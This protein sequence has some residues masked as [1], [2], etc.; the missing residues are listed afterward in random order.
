MLLETDFAVGQ[1]NFTDLIINP[2]S[3]DSF[4]FFF[5][6]RTNRLVKRFILDNT[7][8]NVTY[9]CEVTLIRKGEK[10]APRLHFTIKDESGRLKRVRA[11]NSEDTIHLKASVSLKECYAQF[12]DLISYLKGLADIEG[13]PS[14]SFSLVSRADAEIVAALRQRDAGSIRSII[15]QLSEGVALSHDE[16]VELLQRKKRLK[17]FQHCLEQSA[18]ESHWQEFFEQN[19][20]IFGYGL[21]YVI[22]KVEGQQYVGGQ[23]IDHKG[24]QYPDYL[25]ITTGDVRF[26]VLVE[27]KGPATPLVQGRNE[28]RSGAWSLSKELTD[29]LAQVQ[30]NADRWNREGAR[31]DENRETL[32]GAGVYTVKPRSIIVIGSLAQLKGKLHKLQTFER[33]RRSISDVEILT[34]DEL[35]ERARFIVDH[36]M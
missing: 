23:R 7:H 32:E 13:I 17:E 33:F 18:P 1:D 27:I 6:K 4:Y 11:A 36:Q 31:T 29:A 16:I 22:L 25:G 8:P 24:G 14:G 19:K 10:F 26:T 9:F 12:W 15:R 5:N 3:Q 21:N 30:A 20:W 28:I 34:F 2:T 35:Y